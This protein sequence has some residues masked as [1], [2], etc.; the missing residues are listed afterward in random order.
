MTKTKKSTKAQCASKANYC[1]SCRKPT[2]GDKNLCGACATRLGK[3]TDPNADDFDKH[4]TK[5]FNNTRINHRARLVQKLVTSI[6]SIKSD[7]SK[8]IK[9]QAKK[10]RD[11]R[12]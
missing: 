5:L 12:K 6:K 7:R 11:L 8:K 2:K 9:K 1:R 4:L 10:I 3:I